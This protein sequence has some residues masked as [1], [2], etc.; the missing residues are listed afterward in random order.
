MPRD[1]EIP[2]VERRACS[3]QLG[4][5][6]LRPFPELQGDDQ[7]LHRGHYPASAATGTRLAECWS[8]YTR[9]RETERTP[10]TVAAEH[11]ATLSDMRGDPIVV[12]GDPLPPGR[13][14]H[15]RP[16]R[17]QMMRVCRDFR[18]SSAKGGSRRP[19]QKASQDVAVRRAYHGCTRVYP[20]VVRTDDNKYL[21][22]GI[23]PKPSDGLE[24]STPSLPWNFARNRS[25]PT[26]TVL[27]CFRRFRA[28]PICR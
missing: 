11:A 21:F 20:R 23:L 3:D 28:H 26:A 12:G 27:A 6:L 9:A 15:S 17:Q 19:C 8:S 16:A 25:Q 24:P 18:A 14:S 22:A 13:G 5:L 1:A 4:R 2:S 7:S 10:T